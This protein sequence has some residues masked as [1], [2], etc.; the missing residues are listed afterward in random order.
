M[1]MSD[2]SEVRHGFFSEGVT[3]G[4]QRL[5]QRRV[6]TRAVRAATAAKRGMPRRNEPRCFSGFRYSSFSGMNEKRMRF[7]FLHQRDEVEESQSL[8]E[9]EEVEKSVEVRFKCE[10]LSEDKSD[11]GEDNSEEQRVADEYGGN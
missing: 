10:S 11:D 8:A 2:G 6:T 7:V 4:R 9:N 5:Y 1:T 3:V